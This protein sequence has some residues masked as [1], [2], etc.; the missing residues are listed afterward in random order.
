MRRRENSE[1]AGKII[2]VLQFGS[3]ANLEVELNEGE[4]GRKILLPFLRQ[5]LGEIAVEKGYLEYIDLD[6]F[7]EI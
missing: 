7:L 4:G 2:N 5:N 1:V 6:A 3:Q